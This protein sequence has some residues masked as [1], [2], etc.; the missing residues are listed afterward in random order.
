M[1]A[2]VW[3]M[4]RSFMNTLQPL[5]DGHPYTVAEYFWMHIRY[6]APFTQRLSGE[7]WGPV[8]RAQYE[9]VL[10]HDDGPEMDAQVQAA[11]VDLD[12]MQAAS[13]EK[14]QSEFDEARAASLAERASEAALCAHR[15]KALAEM[16]YEVIALP[17]EQPS[18]AGGMTTQQRMLA[19]LR[20]KL[21]YQRERQLADDGSYASIESYREILMGGAVRRLADR[22]EARERVLKEQ[23]ATRAWMRGLAGV[24]PPPESV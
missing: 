19:D 2:T 13:G 14:W 16:K 15:I 24:V 4:T 11:Q 6:V 10:A 17:D 23:E 7:P 9:Q 22:I 18:P 1:V 12:A 5:L 21:R 8:T 20:D 3:A